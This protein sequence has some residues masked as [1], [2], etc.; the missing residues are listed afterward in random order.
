M[1]NSMYIYIYICIYLFIDYIYSTY[2][3]II[4][5]Y[6]VRDAVNHG[7]SQQITTWPTCYV[8]PKMGYTPTEIAI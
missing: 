7:P 1:L 2:M 4:I 6:D 3:C 8:I 5:S